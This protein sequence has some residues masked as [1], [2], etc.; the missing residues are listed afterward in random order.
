MPETKQEID[1]YDT[2]KLC[3]ETMKERYFDGKDSTGK[4]MLIIA[5]DGP[6]VSC[7][8]CG[9]EGDIGSALAGCCE[10]NGDLR[11]IL[12]FV[13]L[14]LARKT[15]KEMGHNIFDEDKAEDNGI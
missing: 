11:R 10:V 3:A 4:S 7:C 15:L 12:A 9:T 13:N 5:S 8:I 6:D 2:V 1:F 14:Y